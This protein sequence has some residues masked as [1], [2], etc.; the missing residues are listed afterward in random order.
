[1]SSINVT[2]VFFPPIEEYEAQIKRIWENKWLTNRGQLVKELEGKLIEYL[3]VN[4][5]T[6]TTNGTLPMQIAIKAM[7][8]SGEIITTPFS[9]VATTSSIVWEGCKPVFVDIHPEYLTIDEEK[10]EAAKKAKKDKKKNEEDND[11]EKEDKKEEE[12][13]KAEE[14]KIKVEIKRDIP[15]GTA[16]IKGARIIT[17]ENDKIIQNGDILVVNN[18]ISAIGVSGSLSVPRNTQIIDASGKTIIPLI[19]EANALSNSSKSI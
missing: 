8:L 7:G 11:E 5:L 15:K 16:L 10:I 2:R 14:L 9:Y 4:N 17:M 6:L 3:G 13:Y 18:R 19:Q 12:G 1:M